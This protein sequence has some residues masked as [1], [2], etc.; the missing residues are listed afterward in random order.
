MENLQHKHQENKTK[1]DIIDTFRKNV[2]VAQN[3]QG[4]SLKQ[5]ADKMANK[6]KVTS[7]NELL[8]NIIYSSSGTSIRNAIALA[9]TLETSVGQLLPDI[10]T[11]KLQNAQ[12]YML[13]YCQLKQ[14]KKDAVIL[15]TRISQEISLHNI[16][17]KK[18]GNTAGI[19]TSTIQMI[20][21]S[22]TSY[23]ASITT[24]WLIANA[25]QVE[26]DSLLPT[27]DLLAIVEKIFATMEKS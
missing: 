9:Q 26:I 17:F 21:N 16:S 25:L 5:L 3:N 22:L 12:S 7:T 11:N 15:A 27:T 10:E 14:E 6:S 18:L 8:H 19:A 24:L 2:L 20:T 13:L 4:L 1:Q 23:S